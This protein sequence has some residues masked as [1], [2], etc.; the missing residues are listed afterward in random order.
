M[1]DS[2]VEKT[3]NCPTAVRLGLNAAARRDTGESAAR[4]QRLRNLILPADP[5][6]GVGA[7]ARGGPYSPG[8]FQEILE[9]LSVKSD[10]GAALDRG[11]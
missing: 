9:E 11:A 5:P 1:R 10:R 7:R 8:T 6:Q 2:V 4:K 3:P